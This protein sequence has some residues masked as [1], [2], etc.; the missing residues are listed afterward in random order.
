M[1][2]KRIVELDIIRGIAISVVLFA[3]VSEV[4][5]IFEDEKKPHFTSLDYMIKQFFSLFIDGRFIMLFTLLFGIG[6]GIFMNNACKKSLSPL[7]LMFRRLLFLFVV[8]IFGM[9]LSLPYAEY[10]ICGAV[11]MWLFLLPQARYNLWISI[12]TLL[13]INIMT[14]VD[15]NSNLYLI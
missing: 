5:P 9:I 1:D 4:L 14:F 8:G 12:L 7:K 2:K 3:N 13:S 15:T 11:I 10:A 6:M